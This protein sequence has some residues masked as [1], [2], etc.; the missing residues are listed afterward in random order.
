MRRVL[1]ALVIAIRPRAGLWALLAVLFVVVYY[2]SLMGAL[3]ARFENW[4]NYAVVHDWPTNVIHILRS[5]PSLRDAAA[6]AQEEWLVEIGYMN[7]SFGHGISEW[8]L[9]LIPQKILVILGLGALVSTL[10]ALTAARREAFHANADGVAV[11]ACG[12]GGSLV[13][14]TGATMAWVVCCATPTWI[15]GLAMMGLGV[16]TANWLEPAGGYLAAG[17]FAL[18]IFAV[19]R[20][21]RDLMRRRATYDVG[22]PTAAGLAPPPFSGRSHVTE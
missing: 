8:S 14:L 19:H 15:V 5:T 16:A 17:G 6:I 4:P 7:R 13:A 2:L 11:A 21:A 20:L 1:D 9:V 3:V 18:L 10:W 12:A 22:G